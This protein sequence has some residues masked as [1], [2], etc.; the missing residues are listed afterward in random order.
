MRAYI[1][2]DGIR[3]FYASYTCILV[4]FKHLIDDLN[5]LPENI[6]I[7]DDLFELYGPIKTWFNYNNVLN[8]CPDD[9]R[10]FN[11][12]YTYDHEII[13]L[14]P[15]IPENEMDRFKY[16][17]L[18]PYNERV[19]KLVDTN[20]LNTKDCIGIH[21]RG[22]DGYIHIDKIPV[23]FYVEHAIKEMD[24]LNTNS[25]FLCT[26]EEGVIEEFHT[27]LPDANIIYHDTIKSDTDEGVHYLD[28]SREQKIQLADEVILDSFAL[29]NCRSL[30]CRTS[31]VITNARILNPNLTDIIYLEK[32]LKMG[33][34]WMGK[35]CWDTY[36]C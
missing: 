5:Y 15:W 35:Y 23:H 10:K 32:I 21:Y 27:Q 30:I 14:K 13:K 1:H 6:Y 20:L 4:L 31:N 36:T 16:I 25:I 26:D 28:F 11:A 18:F 9:A 33:V 7:S 29:S 2:S 19:R 24:R 8:E 22:T 3:G 12:T 34:R 17:N